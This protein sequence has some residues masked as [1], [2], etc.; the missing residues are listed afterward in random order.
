MRFQEILER[1]VQEEELGGG[2]RDS[3][4]SPL[5]VLDQLIVHGHDAHEGLSRRCV[6]VQQESDP[7]DLYQGETCSWSLFMKTGSCFSLIRAKL[8]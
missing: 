3:W 4:I 1:E 8:C 5:E 2:S 7:Q 6:Q